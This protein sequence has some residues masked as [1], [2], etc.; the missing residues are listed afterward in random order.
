MM[1]ES[2]IKARVQ[3]IWDDERYHY[4]TA[5]LEINAPLAMIQLALEVEMQALCRVLEIPTKHPIRKGT[6]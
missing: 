3:E 1:K 4:R 2:K 6:W 5:T